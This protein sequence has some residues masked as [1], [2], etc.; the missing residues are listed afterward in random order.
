MIYDKSNR[1]IKKSSQFGPHDVNWIKQ[2]YYVESIR[3]HA[4]IFLIILVRNKNCIEITENISTLIKY[5][6]VLFYND[7]CIKYE[8]QL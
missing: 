7:I 5:T 8:S 3:I 1:K 2:P 6:D 4:S